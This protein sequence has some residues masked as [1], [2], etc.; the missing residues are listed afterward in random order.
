MTVC[1]PSASCTSPQCNILKDKFT[2][3]LLENK[4]KVV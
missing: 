1:T 3:I 2:F 4:V